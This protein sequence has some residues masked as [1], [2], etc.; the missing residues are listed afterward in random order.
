MAINTVGLV[1]SEIKSKAAT[2]NN[3]ILPILLIKEWSKARSTDFLHLS[4]ILA[5]GKLSLST[6]KD[7]LFSPNGAYFLFAGTI[8]K[9]YAK[10]VVILPN[11]FAF[12]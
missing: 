7:D 6:I 1:N 10:K 12:F 3:T 8:S 4:K 9:A 5:I 2:I 11:G